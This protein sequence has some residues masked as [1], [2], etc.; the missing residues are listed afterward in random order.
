MYEPSGACKRAGTGES[1]SRTGRFHV[2]SSPRAAGV[3]AFHRVL[4]VAPGEPVLYEFQQ[5]GGVRGAAGVVEIGVCI[6][7]EPISEDGT[8]GPWGR[9]QPG[10][11]GFAPCDPCLNESDQVA[12]T[13]NPD[14]GRTLS[15]GGLDVHSGEPVA[16]VGR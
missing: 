11:S 15:M 10:P 1:T 4:E 12:Q 6:A 2:S 5:I 14:G 8:H 7:R 3:C 9:A 13:G 16:Q